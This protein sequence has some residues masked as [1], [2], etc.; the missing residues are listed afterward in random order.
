M[1]NQKILYIPT[2]GWAAGLKP[3]PTAGFGVHFGL[4][5][6]GDRFMT[7]TFTL[8]SNEA[9]MLVLEDLFPTP[10]GSEVPDQLA[11][12]ATAYRV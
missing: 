4:S 11:L 3:H 1:I 12:L 10:P 7:D 2:G 5:R 8:V 6:I 9:V